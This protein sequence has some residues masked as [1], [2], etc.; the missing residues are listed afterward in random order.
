MPIGLKPAR[1]FDF[2]NLLYCKKKLLYI[3]KVTENDLVHVWEIA[4]L[5]ELFYVTGQEASNLNEL[6]QTFQLD[7]TTWYLMLDQKGDSYGLIRLVP[8]MDE[9]LSIHG[10]GW[11]QPGN[12]PR[13]FVLSWYAF[14]HFLFSRG[15]EII[16]TYC[17]A[18]N[19]NALRFLIKSGYSY[20]YT[21]PSGEV[22]GNTLHLTI[23]PDDFYKYTGSHSS[24]YDICTSSIKKT[25]IYLKGSKASTNRY[26]NQGY[27]FNLINEIEKQSIQKTYLKEQY[28]YFFQL[29][30]PPP[31]YLITFNKNRFS[32]LLINEINGQK[33]I[34]VL[35]IQN[36]TLY[37]Y[38]DFINFLTTT[39]K[40][41]KND[42]I[43]IRESH[44]NDDL[45]NALTISFKFAGAHNV[46]KSNV[47]IY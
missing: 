37:Q 47:W 5:T 40:F 33:K 32:E 26:K 22:N 20:Q 44:V 25:L 39:F 23:T 10:I 18:I 16:R 1:M 7:W 34:V 36:T 3:K 43:F 24:Q 21:M 9:S 19:T 27:N 42:V 17:S 31:V 4:P 45:K 41:N 38:L 6:I 14:H 13:N 11:T 46:S 8:E 28:G 12:S 29:L 15:K 35:T 2:P 30:P